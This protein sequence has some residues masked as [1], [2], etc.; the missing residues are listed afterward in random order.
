[1][2]GQCCLQTP[3]TPPMAVPGFVSCT[4]WGALG[5][6]RGGQQEK[7]GEGTWGKPQRRFWRPLAALQRDSGALNNIGSGKVHLSYGMERG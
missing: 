7:R 3:S 1:M 6:S 4:M 2:R 5:F